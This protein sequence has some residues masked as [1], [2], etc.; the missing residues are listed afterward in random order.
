LKIKE[1][2]IIFNK[3]KNNTSKMNLKVIFHIL[4]AIFYNMFMKLFR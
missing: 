1:Y 2:M 4:V 3:R